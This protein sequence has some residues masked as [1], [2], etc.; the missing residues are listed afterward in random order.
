[1]ISPPILA[2]GQQLLVMLLLFLNAPGIGAIL[3]GLSK[4]A[5]RVSMAGYIC[6]AISIVFGA[7]GLIVI[8]EILQ[9]DL[10]TLGFFTPLPLGFV[11]VVLST[12][13]KP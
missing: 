2:L 11:G 12:R 10:F 13:S 4:K 8:L 1:M 3:L 5:D 6:S 9:F 7:F